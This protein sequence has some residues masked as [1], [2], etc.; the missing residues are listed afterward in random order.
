V[1][2]VISLL[3]SLLAFT[4]ALAFWVDRSAV[5]E[6]AFVDHAHEV[7][8]MR[9]TREALASR[10]MDEAVE[11]VPLLALVR[12]AGERAIV[13]LIESGAFDEAIDRLV[14][15]AHRY[16][17]AGARGP[18]V[19][20]L[21]DV[22]DVLVAP[23]A[24]ISPDLA[25][26]IPVDAFESVVILDSDALP[27]VGTAARWLP[28]IAIFAAAAAVFLAVTL[29]MLSSRRAV[30]VVAVGTALLVAGLGVVAWAGLGGDLA[31]DRISDDLTRVLVVNGTVVFA[32]SLR[33]TGTTLALAG[34]ALAVFGAGMVVVATVR[35]GSVRATR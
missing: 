19:A 22:R 6:V 2:I 29:V 35:R 16:V 21:T 8:A 20:D 11:A 34:A 10:V 15:E 23:I 26:Q 7:L 33:S 30:A 31:A 28:A 12:G 1:T 5:D 24:R 4:A 17:V 3:I 18:F 13:L 14:I 32:R 25:A 9:S 27:V